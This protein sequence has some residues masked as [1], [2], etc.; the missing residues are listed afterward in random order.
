MSSRHC[1]CAC[2]SPPWLLR[3][4]RVMQACAWACVAARAFMLRLVGTEQVC[5]ARVP[6]PWLLRRVVV[7][8]LCA[9]VAALYS[10]SHRRDAGVRVC[11]CLDDCLVAWAW[12]RCANTSLPLLRRV[13]VVL[14]SARARAAALVASSRGRD[15][16]ARGVAS[17]AS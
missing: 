14:A 16:G 12:C 10:S 17:S 1:W 11:R 3:R 13:G 15:A 6:R 5:A 2:A 4:V 8:Q 7:V 9:C